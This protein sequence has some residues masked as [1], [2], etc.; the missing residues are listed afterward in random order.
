MTARWISVGVMPGST[1]G[2]EV[3]GGVV[4]LVVGGEV[5]GGFVGGDVGARVG[6]D[7]GATV[8]ALVGATLGGTTTTVGAGEVDGGTVGFAVPAAVGGGV[9][10][11]WRV[12]TTGSVG[13]VPDVETSFVSPPFVSSTVTPMPAARAAAT[14]PTVIQIWLRVTCAPACWSVARASL[15]HGRA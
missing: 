14:A 3:V 9:V 13:R 1:A 2:A 7:V 12:V 11:G 8:G 6:G 4:G 15:A 5:D 10:A